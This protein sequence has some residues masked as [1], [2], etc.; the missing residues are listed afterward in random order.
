MGTPDFAVPSLQV[1]HQEGY[2]LKRIVTQPDRPRGRGR[3][4]APPPVKQK[5]LALQLHLLQPERPNSTEF[6]EQLLQIQPDLLVVIA[7]GHLLSEKILQIPKIGAINVHASLLPNYRGPAPI[8]WAIIN[9]ETQTGV[10][11]MFMDAGMDTGDMLISRP[12]PILPTDTAATLHD[13]LA[14][15][16]AD[17]LRQTLQQLADQTLQS[18]QQDH[19][20]A[21][22]APLL[23]KQDGRID[24]QKSAAELEPFIRGMTP[25]PGAFTFHNQNRLKIFKSAPLD[26]T[27]A[28][29]A[30]T[31]LKG[32]PDE[33]VVATGKGAL[34]NFEIQG[35]SGKRLKIADFLRGYQLAPGT[36]LQ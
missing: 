10:T 22:Y 28:A 4:P 27:I 5:A 3:K 14:M 24:W 18:A 21:T 16:G 7:Y 6:A 1:L 25:W 33:L 23:K 17:T 34:S 19:D 8:Q 12:E 15:L 32:F 20:K 31:I 13:R 30:G 2:H 35:P 9:G 36:V 26:Q 29:P 11:T